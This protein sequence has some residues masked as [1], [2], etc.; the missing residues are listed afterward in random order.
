MQDGGPIHPFGKR[1]WVGAPA[2]AWRAMPRV[3]W[4]RYTTVP[5][6]YPW[7]I[8]TGAEKAFCTIESIPVS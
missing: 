6:R 5:N 7:P 8:S 4:Y 2:P 1:L 3:I